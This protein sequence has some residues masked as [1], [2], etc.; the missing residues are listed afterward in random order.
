MIECE[1]DRVMEELGLVPSYEATQSAELR[2][3]VDAHWRTHY[4][5]EELLVIWGYNQ[6][7][8]PE[9]DCADLKR[10]RKAAPE[11]SAVW[12]RRAKKKLPQSVKPARLLAGYEA[13]A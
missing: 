9:P 7:L 11:D 1:F 10:M 8:I 3:W 4:V 13:R 6:S 5:L 2:R 12:R